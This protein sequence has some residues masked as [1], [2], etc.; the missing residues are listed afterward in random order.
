MVDKTYHCSKCNKIFFKEYS[1][2]AHQCSGGKHNFVKR[3]GTSKSSAKTSQN[4]G[5]YKKYNCSKCNATFN[6]SQSRN[7]HMR[8]H[9]QAHAMVGTFCKFYR[10]NL[11]KVLRFTN[12]IKCFLF[13]PPQLQVRKK[14]LK[15]EL[16]LSKAMPK[17]MPQQTS[18][19]TSVPV[20][21]DPAP[22]IKIDDSPTPPVLKR[23]LIRTAGG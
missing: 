15:R 2:L 11:A 18:P 19:G 13:Y 12:V 1:L 17:L 23:T 10:M 7:S 14:E 22:V 20:Q 21:V 4:F 5:A 8:V 6:N 16:E 9:T 3:G